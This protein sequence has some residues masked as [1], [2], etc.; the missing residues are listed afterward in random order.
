M[1]YGEPLSDARTPLADFFRILLEEE[2]AARTKCGLE[3]PGGFEP[4]HRS[5]AACPRALRPV[6]IN[7]EG[8]RLIINNINILRAFHCDLSRLT[9]TPNREQNREWDRE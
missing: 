5:F 2:H 8:Q 1:P 6:M 9:S 7:K 4:P 3:A